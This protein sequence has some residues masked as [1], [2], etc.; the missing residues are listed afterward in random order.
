[1]EIFIKWFKLAS[2]QPSCVCCQSVLEVID[3]LLDV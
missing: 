3:N 2:V 1:M